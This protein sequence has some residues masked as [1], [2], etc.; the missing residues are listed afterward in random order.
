[1]PTQQPPQFDPEVKSILDRLDAWC[2]KRHGGQALIGRAMGVTT[3]QVYDWLSAQRRA[4]T[5][6]VVLRLKA[7]AD[8]F[9]ICEA[10]AQSKKAA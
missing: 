8:F 5:A 2:K 4:P 9:D 1:M 6:N 10:D 7:L 3:Q